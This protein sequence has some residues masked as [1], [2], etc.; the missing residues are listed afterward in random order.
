MIRGKLSNIDSLIL[1]DLKEDKKSCFQH[2][3]ETHLWMW[4]VGH[5]FET[6]DT[7]I[8]ESITYQDIYEHV[9]YSLNLSISMWILG[10]IVPRTFIFLNLQA[11][12][13][14]YLYPSK[15]YVTNHFQ[16]HW[17]QILCINLTVRVGWW[18][19]LG[20]ISGVGWLTHIFGD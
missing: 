3:I 15:C 1:F 17:L 9:D 20:S 11:Y 19:K 6:S 7:G 14:H 2:P 10:L 5:Q 4:R 18:V 8:L 16:T 13:I 12:C